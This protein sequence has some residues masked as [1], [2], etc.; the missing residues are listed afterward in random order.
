MI[1]LGWHGELG[2]GL[3]ATTGDGHD[4]SILLDEPPLHLL[5][6]ILDQGDLRVA[7][8]DGSIQIL[9]EQQ[10][11]FSFFGQVPVSP[12][13]ELVQELVD[14]NISSRLEGTERNLPVHSVLFKVQLLL[15]VPGHQVTGPHRCELT[16]VLCIPGKVAV[17]VVVGGVDLK[18]LPKVI[19]R[20]VD[21]GKDDD[22]E[23]SKLRVG[24]LRTLGH[25]CH[26]VVVE[27]AHEEHH[28]TANEIQS[29]G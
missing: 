28:V 7:L 17:V 9:V 15:V 14:R 13:L 23:V 20:L 26:H 4:T 5:E 18:H 16:L 11:R 3:D 2:D 22:L 19:D 8:R 6:I 25:I 27:L 1:A 12:R 24:D 10:V 21:L 29:V